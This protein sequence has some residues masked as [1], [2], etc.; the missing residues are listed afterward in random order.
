MSNEIL[1]VLG[2]IG[3]YA[4]V[5]IWYKLFGR[6]GLYCFVGLVTVIANI[7]VLLLID[8]FGLE[9]TLGNVAFAAI[10]LATDML[11]EFEGKECAAKAVKMGAASLILFTLFSQ[12]W[13]LFTP[14]QNDW[15]SESFA[16]LFANTPRVMIASLVV[17][18]ISQELDVFLYHLIWKTTE[19][20]SGSK[21]KFLWVRNNGST[22]TSQLV[23]TVLFNLLAFWGVYD[24]GTLLSIIV[25]G[26]A[27]YVV[28]S[29]C[30]TPIMYLARSLKKSGKL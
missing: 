20:F 7:E 3:L 29:I 19:K 26:Y 17:Y 24:G 23:N 6:T 15:A 21:E 8:A 22:L 27:I 30:D 9:Q 18:V 25:A 16:N 5:I 1:L 12:I 28:T 11:S 14:S 4:M 2:M 10:F 13:L